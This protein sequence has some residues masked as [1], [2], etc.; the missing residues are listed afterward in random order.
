MAKKFEKLIFDAKKNKGKQVFIL[1]LGTLSIILLVTLSVVYLNA[2]KI[3][4]KPPEANPFSLQVLEGSGFRLGDRFISR[5]SDTGLEL[6]QMVFRRNC[7]INA[8]TTSK[9]VLINV[10]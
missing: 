10:I 9:P 7:H 4:V 2:V 8:E 1:S 5:G 6:L 3:I